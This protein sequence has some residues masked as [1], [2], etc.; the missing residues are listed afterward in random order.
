MLLAEY[1]KL[2]A[3]FGFPFYQALKRSLPKP[4][5]RYVDVDL[6]DETLR[7]RFVFKQ[8]GTDLPLDLSFVRH[9]YLIVKDV[10]QAGKNLARVEVESSYDVP[11][12]KSFNGSLDAVLYHVTSYF[13][14]NR[15]RLVEGVPANENRGFTE[16]HSFR[17]RLLSALKPFLNGYIHVGVRDILGPYV[18]V[19]F[20]FT[21]SRSDVD[22]LNA[23]H[24]Q[25]GIDGWRPGRSPQEQV[26]EAELL[27]FKDVPRFRRKR[28]N[29]EQVAKAIVNYFKK[30]R[31]ALLSGPPYGQD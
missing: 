13:Q 7:I 9:L 16:A 19:E 17:D 12:F 23:K 15:S 14:N 2:R 24:V 31:P 3:T 28:G 27:R 8:F 5:E 30:A 6:R 22:R 18:N 1:R 29:A 4:L 25:I 20:A 11:P 10:S 26:L 21:K